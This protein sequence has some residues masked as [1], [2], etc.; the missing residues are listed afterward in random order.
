MPSAFVAVTVDRAAGSFR[1]F[2]AKVCTLWHRPN[3]YSKVTSCRHFLLFFDIHCQ[4]GKH[5]I[6]LLL[7]PL[8][9]LPQINGIFYLQCVFLLGHHQ[10]ICSRHL[11]PRQVISATN[12]PLSVMLGPILACRLVREPSPPQITYTD[13]I[14]CPRSLISANTVPKLS[15]T[16][17]AP[18]LQQICNSARLSFHSARSS[19]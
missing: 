16:P 12:I 2:S 13:L 7:H 8:I 5:R 19:F 17:K 15:H 6:L 4:L 10:A 18:A 9:W 11:R 3:L 14:Y 1:H